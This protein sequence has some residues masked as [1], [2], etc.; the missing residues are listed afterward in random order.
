VW[1]ALAALSGGMSIGH[2]NDSG[3]WVVTKLSG[4][5]LSGGLKIY[6]LGEFI[7]SSLVFIMALTG[8]MILPRF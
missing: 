3:F 5:S 6:T 8:S 2:V 7:V 1:L 4:F